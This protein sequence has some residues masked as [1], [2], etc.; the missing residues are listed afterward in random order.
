MGRMKFLLCFAGVLATAANACEMLEYKRVQVSA[1]VHVFQSA[2]G[3]TG[4]VNGNIAAVVG[5]DAILVVDT[6]QFLGIARRIVADIR[7]MSPQPVRYV[8]NTHWHGDHLLANQVFKEAFPEARIVA[9]GFTIAEGAKRYADYATRTGQQL[10][11]L[12]DQ[13]MK[14]AADPSATADEK[15]WLAK[16]TDCAEKVL[17]DVAQTRYIAPDMPVDT[18][19]KVDLGGV[20][21]LIRHIGTGNTPGDLIVWVPEDRVVMSGDMVVSPAPYA[22]GS[23]GLEAWARTLG[24]LR[25]LRA[26][27]IVPG[28]GPPMR[29]DTYVRDVQELLETTR[30][31]LNDMLARGVSRADAAKQL[32][33][34]RLR[35][36]YITTPMRRQAFERFFVQSAINEVWPK[37]QPKPEAA[38]EEAQRK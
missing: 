18:E 1:H 23:A 6:G 17:P 32:D 2:E 22:I 28:H 11:I 10:P 29:D 8:V 9:H 19:M 26:T 12:I 21:A 35:E 33:V 30:A 16:T 5:K 15:L 14:R 3:T 24:E 13:A 20:T 34:A 25:G 36:R 27:V 31:Q 7:A 4:V 37:P 38:K